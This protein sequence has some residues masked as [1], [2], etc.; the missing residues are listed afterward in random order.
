MALEAIQLLAATAK[1]DNG[2]VNNLVMFYS[3]LKTLLC[4]SY[5]LL[6]LKSHHSVTRNNTLI[7]TPI[8]SVTRY[9]TLIVTPIHSRLHQKS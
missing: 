1:D 2:K 3:R 8:Q 5:N 4:F 6:T 7:V 9:K